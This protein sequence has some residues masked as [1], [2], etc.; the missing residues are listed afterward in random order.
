MEEIQSQIDK[1]Q[2]VANKKKAMVPNFARLL[3]NLIILFFVLSARRHVVEQKSF[4]TSCVK[5]VAR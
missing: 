3:A 2:A 4:S 5:G 1:E